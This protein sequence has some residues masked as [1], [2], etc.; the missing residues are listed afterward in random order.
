[1]ETSLKTA[2]I[3]NN[4]NSKAVSHC[5]VSSIETTWCES[6]TKIFNLFGVASPEKNAKKF[7]YPKTKFPSRVNQEIFSAK[8]KKKELE[9]Y[10]VHT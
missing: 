10:V 1:M 5:K 6:T 4:S 2:I 9:T 3:L 7:V 8:K